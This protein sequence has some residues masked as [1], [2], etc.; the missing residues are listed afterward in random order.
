MGIERLMAWI[1]VSF[2]REFHRELVNICSLWFGDLEFSGCVVKPLCL[3]ALTLDL[4]L[5]IREENGNLTYLYVVLL[6]H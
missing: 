3:S 4:Q 5:S 1:E 2:S 6:P